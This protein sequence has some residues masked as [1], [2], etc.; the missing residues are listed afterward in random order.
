[1]RTMTVVAGA[2]GDLGEPGAHDPRADD[3]DRACLA[4]TR[5]EP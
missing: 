4:V 3:A 2:G 5:R 1:M